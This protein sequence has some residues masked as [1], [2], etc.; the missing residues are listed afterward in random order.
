MERQ[1]DAIDAKLAELGGPPTYNSLPA[2]FMNAHQFIQN[3]EEFKTGKTFRENAITKSKQLRI[4]LET[5]LESA[6]GSENSQIEKQIKSINATIAAQVVD[7][8]CLKASYMEFL[9]HTRPMDSTA[10]LEKK[11][12]LLDQKLTLLEKLRTHEALP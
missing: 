4:D 6:V 11:H 2:G 7:L 12:P 9:T 8:N 3:M 5:A 1:I 10:F